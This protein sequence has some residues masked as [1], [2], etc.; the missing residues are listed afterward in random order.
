[1]ARSD[2]HARDLNA[3]HAI[4]R[5]RARFDVWTCLARPMPAVLLCARLRGESSAR[6]RSRSVPNLPLPTSRCVATRGS[7]P[8]LCS[9]LHGRPVRPRGCVCP[10][11]PGHPRRGPSAV[12]A[13]ASVPCN[14][15]SSAAGAIRNQGLPVRTPGVPLR[16]ARTPRVPATA[17][18]ALARWLPEGRSRTSIGNAEAIADEPVTLGEHRLHRGGRVGEA[19]VRRG[20]DNPLAKLA[21]PA[22]SG[23]SSSETANKTHWYTSPRSVEPTGPI[24]PAPGFRSASG[25]KSPRT[26]TSSRRSRAGAQGHAPAGGGAGA[27]QTAA[28]HP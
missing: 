24:N 20:V 5:L 19:V 21:N 7:S 28:A 16:A 2:S 23:P 10:T 25:G 8:H 15:L 27:P 26:R 13:V 3:A 18:A 11:Q 14:R 17:P 1:M 12:Q 22:K 9:R 6:R 4:V